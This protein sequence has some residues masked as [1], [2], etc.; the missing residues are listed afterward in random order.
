[1]NKDIQTQNNLEKIEK[2]RILVERSIMN[3]NEMYSF[4]SPIFL[5]ALQK[6][7][8]IKLFKK[9][10]FDDPF[11]VLQRP[12]YK[13]EIENGLNCNVDTQEYF[14]DNIPE[15][16]RQIDAV[17]RIKNMIELHKKAKIF[18]PSEFIAYYLGTFYYDCMSGG[19]PLW[20][21]VIMNLFANQDIINKNTKIYPD[22]VEKDTWITIEDFINEMKKKDIPSIENNCK[23]LALEIIK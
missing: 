11:I 21:L 19:I 13:I 20:E 8:I 10:S 15:I 14:E 16:T 18:K 1:M 22:N 2:F 6:T 3:N 5:D 9:S 23:L 17:Y 4:Y 12:V 7:E